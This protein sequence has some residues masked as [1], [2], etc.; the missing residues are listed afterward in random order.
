MARNPLKDQVAVVGVGSTAYG[1]D[2]QRS[3]LSLGV[4]AALKAMADAGIDRR[5]IDGICGSGMSPLAVGNA[6]FLSV[7]GALGIEKVTWGKNGWLGSAF[8]FAVEAVFSG[9]CD[10]CLV[11]QSYRREVNMSRSAARDP[12][13]LRAS[14]FGETGGMG[15]RDFAR[16]WLH[17]GEPYAAWMKRY[18]HD[19]GV[20][21]DAFGLMAVNNRSHGARNPDAVIQRAITLDDYHASRMV[22]EPMQMLDMDIP[23]DG[24]EAFVITTAERARDL[25][26]KPV[27]VHAMSLGGTRVGEFYENTLPWT[28]NAFWVAMEGLWARSDLTR[29][30]VDLFYP[31]DG[32]TID[33]VA[34]VEAAGF[35]KPGE[36]GDYFRDCWDRR[37]NI[38]RLNGGRTL[39]TTG[40]GGLAHGRS[41]GSN[42]YAEA[43]RQLR[44]SQGERQ[45]RH[46]DS[47]LITIGSMY[48][49]PSAVL[50]RAGE[51]R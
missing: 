2:Q 45:A 27:T 17:S 49:D 18:M 50:L 10:T 8:V 43:V 36:A 19:Y 32:Y 3:L 13:R 42:L 31:Y 51:R 12:F 46:A 24:A 16:R 34:V 7:Q 48:H 28:E 9:L 20:G 40:G 25:R 39:V 4:E 21:K 37:E 41:G 14:R 15:G 22:W 44:G 30:D 47:A 26:Q 35:C 11:V 29:T 33:A 23:V 5:G 38:L 1:R 6:G